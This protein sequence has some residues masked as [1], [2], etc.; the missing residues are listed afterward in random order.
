[1]AGKPLEVED[2]SNPN[3]R[4]GRGSVGAS[5]RACQM[6]A[7]EEGQAADFAAEDTAAAAGNTAAVE[8]AVGA[9]T[10]V[11]AHSAA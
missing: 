7:A 4:Y 2:Q 8:V 6:T 9:L 3:S 10:G 11:E 5:A 1:M